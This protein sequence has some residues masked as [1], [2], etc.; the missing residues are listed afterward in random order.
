MTHTDENCIFCKLA[1]G[2]IPT[3]FVYESDDI[4]AFDDAAPKAPVHILIVPKKHIASLQTTGE[5]DREMLA[6]ILHAATEIAKAAG[7]SESG[8]RVLTNIGDDGGQTIHHLH[9]HV[10]GGRKLAIDV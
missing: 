4:C 10:I 2:I 1:N 7:I 9:F 8:Y 6:E 5:E 3:E